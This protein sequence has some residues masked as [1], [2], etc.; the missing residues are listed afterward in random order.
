MSTARPNPW[1][2]L[3]VLCVA[4]FLVLLDT[5]IVNTAVPDM[6]TGL[7]VGIGEIL[8]ILN[9]YLLAL[10]SLLVFFG[11]LGD[12]AGPKRLFVLG[13]AVFTLASALCAL[14]DDPA[15]LI[16]A[17]VAQGIGAAI[18]S[19]QAFVLIAAIF[20]AERRGAA[21]G[22]FTA[23]AGIA[24]IS[25]P[26]LGGLLVT[27]FGW[28]SVFLLNVPVGLA[29]IVLAL[30]VVPDARTGRPHRFDVV[31]VLLVTAGLVGVVYGLI[32]KT[33]T[34]AGFT[35]GIAALAAFV[36]WER[37]RKDPLIPLGLYR[38]R[39]YRI[40]TVLTGA[41]AFSIAGFLLVFVLL[42]QNLLGMSPL[43]SGVAALPW[44]LALSA[45]APVAGRLADRV[46]GR[47]LLVGGLAL[48]AAG[49][50]ATALLP[51]EKS[52]A[53]VFLVPLIA[54]GVGQGLA[55][56]PATTEA[57]RAI[58]PDAAGAASGVLNTARHVGS[59]LGA[60]VAG[61]LFQAGL[62]GGELAAARTT[63]LMLAAV[64]AAAALLA[65]R[66]PALTTESHRPTAESVAV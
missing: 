15:W 37:G 10:A 42:T 62:A 56:A 29:G 23:V 5:T 34:I 3:G 52:T 54:V 44:T 41:T 48:Y 8:W 61:V 39:G 2:V 24:A 59:A 43:M 53:A 4:N 30:R 32:E 1:R 51:D 65:V 19:P 57:L 38:D 27:R 66:V 14:A 50:T 13:L 11:R 16:A 49:V 9:G 63:F 12:L 47:W 6:M 7:D 18:L 22:L 26:T 35:A 64:L 21:F 25:G 60:A 28:Q 31:G 55:I 36:L 40:A 33:G 17:R 58:P 46:G 20:P 45:V